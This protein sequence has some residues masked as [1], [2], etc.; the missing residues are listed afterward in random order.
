MVLRRCLT[1]VLESAL[2]NAWQL[3]IFTILILTLVRIVPI[4]R[5]EK[6]AY[7]STDWPFQLQKRNGFY[8]LRA[9]YRVDG[10]NKSELKI[11]EAYVRRNG[12]QS[13]LLSHKD[14]ELIDD[15]HWRRPIDPR[16]YLI[17]PQPLNLNDTIRRLLNSTPIV[18]VRQAC[19]LQW[20]KIS[21][22]EMS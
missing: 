14:L 10:T 2:R 9:I 17:Y 7:Y 22:I 8:E 20:F 12:D 6:I 18:E 3:G 4:L 1:R 11:P 5:R 16:V 13:L 19:Y 21:I 15:S